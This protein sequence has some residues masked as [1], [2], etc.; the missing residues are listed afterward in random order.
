MIESVGYM[1]SSEEL[2]TLSE[3]TDLA[4]VSESSTSVSGL[5][6]SILVTGRSF[7]HS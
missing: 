4:L 7:A 2:E 6:V 5:V 1:S 3:S